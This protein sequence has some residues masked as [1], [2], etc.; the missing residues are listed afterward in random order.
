MKRGV[1]NLF[2]SLVRNHDRILLVKEVDE[3]EEEGKRIEQMK[4]RR[5][6]GRSTYSYL[7]GDFGGE[8]LLGSILVAFASNTKLWTKSFSPAKEETREN[9]VKRRQVENGGL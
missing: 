1:E 2:G 8:H 9:V 5:G 3:G 6:E 7:F 4:R